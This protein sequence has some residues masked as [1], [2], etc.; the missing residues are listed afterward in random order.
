MLWQYLFNSHQDWQTSSQNSANQYVNVMWTLDLSWVRFTCLSKPGLTLISGFVFAIPRR[1]CI[2]SLTS[3]IVLLW[4][5]YD[6]SHKYLYQ[7][8][9]TCER[10]PMGNCK[11]TTYSPYSR[12]KNTWNQNDRLQSSK[13]LD[14]LVPSSPFSVQNVHLSSQPLSENLLE[15]DWTL[16]DKKNTKK[17]NKGM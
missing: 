17:K 5:I 1:S 7:L 2:N 9:S 8:W 6:H 3:P 13:V 11:N 10:K 15:D 14:K 12:K 4:P 16:L